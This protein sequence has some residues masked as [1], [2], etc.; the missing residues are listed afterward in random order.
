MHLAK[1]LLLGAATCIQMRARTLYSLL[2]WLQ[3]K[4]EST[5]IDP[6]AGGSDTDSIKNILMQL[7][8]RV[9]LS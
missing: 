5:E 7:D 9:E 1:Q 6:N 4:R 3:L 2:F 8:S